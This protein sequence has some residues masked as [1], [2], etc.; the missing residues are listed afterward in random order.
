MTYNDIEKLE[1]VKS[2]DEVTA[3]SELSS[4]LMKEYIEYEEKRKEA[5]KNPFYFFYEDVI[6]AKLNYLFDAALGATTYRAASDDARSCL[7]ICNN[8]K[9][10]NGYGTTV[11]L[12]AAL[13]FVDNIVLHYIQEVCKQAPKKYVDAGVEKSRYVQLAKMS[14]KPATCGAVLKN[15][16]EMR[17]GLEHRTITKDDGKQELITPSKNRLRRDVNKLYPVALTTLLES[18]KIALSTYITSS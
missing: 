8:F 10:M 9:K 18:Y 17:N 13:K 12:G 2:S 16:Y 7:L 6:N 11:W 5:D 3:Q 15:L 1:Y 4:L 14:G